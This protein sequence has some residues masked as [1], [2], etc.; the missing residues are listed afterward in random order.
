MSH[1]AEPDH[2]AESEW[3][4]MLHSII[5]NIALQQPLDQ[6][7]PEVLDQALGALNL[8]TGWIFLREGESAFR[9]A[10]STGLPAALSS[11][12]QAPLRST[13]CECQQHLLEDRLRHVSQVITC[14]RLARIAHTLGESPLCFHISY[15]LRVAPHN[16]GIMNLASAGEPAALS[17]P[18]RALGLLANQIA[19]VIAAGAVDTGAE[20]ELE[21]LERLRWLDY[22]LKNLVQALALEEDFLQQVVDVLRDVT[23]AR[24]GALA[25][26]DRRGQWSRFFYSGVSR[27]HAAQIGEM[28]Q[29]SGILGM[30]LR[31]GSPLRLGDVAKHPESAG[32]P[33]N[34]PPMKTFMGIPILKLNGR[35]LGRIY[36]ANKISQREFDDLDQRTLEVFAQSVA[37]A[38]E[39]QAEET[40]DVE[41][42]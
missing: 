21:W 19:L 17:R 26:L 27:E 42:A 14:Q 13:L 3:R 34:H 23:G 8:H 25:L 16:L 29:G 36:L 33:P 31:E 41:V 35:P 5:G 39:L 18:I 11:N 40:Y 9:L 28:P 15:P 2:S 12:T 22:A 10:A 1:S 20:G 4:D 38:I 7:L 24:Y 30:L 37:I 6:L 32:F